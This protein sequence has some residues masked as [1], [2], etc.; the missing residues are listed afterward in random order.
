MA[1]TIELIAYPSTSLAYAVSRGGTG[2]P[3]ASYAMTP[4]G[5]S[6]SWEYEI[7]VAESLVGEWT[8]RCGDAEGNKGMRA[9]ELFASVDSYPISKASGSELTISIEGNDITVQ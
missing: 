4:I 3:A 5:A 2:T 8:F 7:T 6:G 1:K 9:V